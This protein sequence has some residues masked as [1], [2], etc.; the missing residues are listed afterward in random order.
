[1]FLQPFSSVTYSV[2]NVL[3]AKCSV[4]SQCLCNG[5]FN[6][7]FIQEN[8]R[9]TEE[10]DEITARGPRDDRIPSWQTAR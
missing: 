4:D 9:G 1:M 2:L 7:S 10:I 3:L 5:N 8:R 6:A